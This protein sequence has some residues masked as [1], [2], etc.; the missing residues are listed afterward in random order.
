MTRILAAVLL[1]AA[2]SVGCSAL[3]AMNARSPVPQHMTQSRSAPRPDIQRAGYDY[4][5]AGAVDCVNSM[6]CCQG[7]GC[8]NGMCG[9]CDGV[10][11]DCVHQVL[12]CDGCCG[13]GDA[14]GMG[15]ACG[16]GGCGPGACGPEGCYGGGYGGMGACSCGHS[17]RC[18][19]C[20]KLRQ[21][22]A[23][24]CRCRGAGQCGVCRC[25]KGMLAAN[26]LCGG[27][28][29][30]PCCQHIKTCIG[31]P[32]AGGTDANYNFNPGPSAAQV[33]YPYYTTRGPRDFFLD[34]PPS[35][36]PY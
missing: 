22:L 8:G 3:D 34:N 31:G 32:I 7:A 26:C 6:E 21:M 27:S 28:G 19:C 33:A 15:G 10:V 11:N 25:V 23:G 20:M 14:C 12:D 18:A 30:C 1:C 17:G 4:P 36:G 16:P 5:A 13:C 9:C 29:Q 35:I 24:G 2:S